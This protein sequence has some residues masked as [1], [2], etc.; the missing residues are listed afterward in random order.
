MSVVDVAMIVTRHE[1]VHARMWLQCR[2]Q[3]LFSVALN[4]SSLGHNAR[5]RETTCT[6]RL[7]TNRLPLTVETH[8]GR[9][10]DVLVDASVEKPTESEMPCGQEG[11]GKEDACQHLVVLLFPRPCAMRQASPT[12]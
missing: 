3:T 5:S 1:F 4:W 6:L 11:T 8:L 9:R 12:T 10:C 7:S 2:L